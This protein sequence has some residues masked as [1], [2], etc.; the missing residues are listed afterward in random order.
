MTTLWEFEEN[1]LDRLA[2][3][4]RDRRFGRN[5][6]VPKLP[7]TPSK[8]LVPKLLLQGKGKLKAEQESTGGPKVM[9][10]TLC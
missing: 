3:A 7:E 6:P 5:S 4:I 8:L 10:W 1:T 9:R 2:L